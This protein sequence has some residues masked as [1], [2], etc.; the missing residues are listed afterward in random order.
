[1]KKMNYKIVGLYDVNPSKSKIV[2]IYNKNNKNS[3]KCLY[4]PNHFSY[5][6]IIAN[7]ADNDISKWF[8]SSS[9]DKGYIRS[10]AYPD[11]CINLADKAT[12][13]IILG[14]CDDNENIIFSY[15]MNNQK[16]LKS[17]S[18]DKCL[19]LLASSNSKLNLNSCTGS[20]DQ[21]WEISGN[22]PDTEK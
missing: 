9:S 1:M 4:A 6:P 21:L 3:K 8:I 7:C 11:W 15:P 19:G 12:G 16:A 17:S 10:V 18:V 20:D 2:W 22:N 13:T 14:K 5:R